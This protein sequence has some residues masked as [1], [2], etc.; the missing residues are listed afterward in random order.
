MSEE[1]KEAEMSEEEEE[2]RNFSRRDGR[3][4]YESVL[5]PPKTI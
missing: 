1:E 3:N 5:S 2:Y 4:L